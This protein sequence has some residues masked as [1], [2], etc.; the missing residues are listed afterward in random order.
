M[1]TVA[2]LRAFLETLPDDTEVHV[3]MGH[4]FDELT[5]PELSP[6]TED[7]AE[8]YEGSYF[9]SSGR[10]WSYEPPRRAREAVPP[11]PGVPGYI[12]GHDGFPAYPR[13]AGAIY[14]G[15]EMS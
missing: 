1:T 9:F 15:R 4:Y 3:S 6:I 10:G 8:F 2:E 14:F 7:Q 12:K 13:V 5:L 11:S